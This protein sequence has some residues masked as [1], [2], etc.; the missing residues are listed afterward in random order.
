MSY[1]FTVTVWEM[2]QLNKFGWFDAEDET[3]PL[4]TAPNWVPHGCLPRLYEFSL[5]HRL[6][7]CIIFPMIEWQFWTNALFGEDN[8][9]SGKSQLVNTSLLFG[10]VHHAFLRHHPPKD[11]YSIRPIASNKLGRKHWRRFGASNLADQAFGGL[12]DCNYWSNGER[13]F[14]K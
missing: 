6:P 2:A 10:E 7:C 1:A 3:A 12:C 9:H 13:Y 4:Q 5:E 11:S 14:A 8:A